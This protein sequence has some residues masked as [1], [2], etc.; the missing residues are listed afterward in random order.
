MKY[1]KLKSLLIINSFFFIFFFIFFLFFPE[2]DIYFSSLFYEN[3]KFISEKIIFIKSLRTFLKDLMVLIPIVA[4][5]ILFVN[6]LKKKKSKTFL[7]L[8]VKLSLLGLIIGP[9]IGSGIIANWYFKDQWGRARPVHITEFG[10]DKYFTQAFVKS[11]QCEKNCSWI[12]G[13]SSA[14]FS[15]FVGTLILKNPLFFFLNLV[16]G[17][18]VSFCRISM[19]GHFLSDNLF[20]LFFMVYLAIAFKYLVIKKRKK[21]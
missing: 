10:G 2:S 21:I 13:E 8:R 4:L 6:F 9:I 19:G 16:F 17:I 3:N 12:S 7:N 5:I 14:A 18:I 15:F 1:L 11:N 20:A